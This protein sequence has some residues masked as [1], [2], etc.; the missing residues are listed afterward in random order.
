[1]SSVEKLERGVTAYIKKWL[2]VPRCLT[3]ISLYGDGILKL[4]ITSLTEEYKCTKVR[5]QM[6]LNESRDIVV[7]ENAPTLTTGRKWKPATA[8]EEATSALRFAEIVGNV[9]PGR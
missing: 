7:R 6:T 8:L 2:G 9:Q 3:T 4:P 1:M 5:L